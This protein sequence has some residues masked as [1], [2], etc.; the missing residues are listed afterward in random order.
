[1]KDDLTSL[2]LSNVSKIMKDK[3]LKQAYLADL[4]GT[5][6]ANMSKILK[7]TVKLQLYH[8]SNL[9]TNLHMSVIDLLTYPV[10]YVP[11]T[12]KQSKT[13]VLVE[14]EISPNELVKMGLKDKVIQVLDK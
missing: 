12:E 8:V 1:M 5:S 9:A 7:G 6:P 11:N 13:K 4:A 14:L 10:I 3:N 2:I